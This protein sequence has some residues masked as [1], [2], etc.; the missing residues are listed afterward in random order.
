[1]TGDDVD[2]DPN[3]G[4]HAGSADSVSAPTACL[5]LPLQVGIDIHIKLGMHA[6]AISACLT[7]PSL[8][9]P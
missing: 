5:H 8:T 2:V 9:I 3:D 7:W 1:M 6:L 4:S